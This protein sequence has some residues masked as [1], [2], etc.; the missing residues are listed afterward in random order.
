M[1]CVFLKEAPLTCDEHSNL[2]WV[3]S[4]S[5]KCPST[6]FLLKLSGRFCYSYL[7]TNLFSSETYWLQKCSASIMYSEPLWLLIPQC[8]V[9]TKT[10][11]GWLID[12]RHSL[13]ESGPANS[14]KTTWYFTV[15]RTRRKNFTLW[16]VFLILPN[17]HSHW[18]EWQNRT[19][20]MLISGFARQNYYVTFRREYL[21][22]HSLFYG[23]YCIAMFSCIIFNLK[24]SFHLMWGLW[25]TLLVHFSINQFSWIFNLCEYVMY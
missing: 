10:T 14:L 21:G 3:C 23:L 19:W 17:K 18:L 24:I 22:P 16:P 9:K 13:E 8:C 5:W 7:F 25:Y 2:G 6:I 1:F 11:S 15:T 12:T 4:I 20:A